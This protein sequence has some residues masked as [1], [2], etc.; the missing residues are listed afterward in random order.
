MMVML[1]PPPL[2]LGLDTA[3]PVPTCIPA[4]ATNCMNVLPIACG[5]AVPV[6]RDRIDERKPAVAEREIR[7][8]IGG[9]AGDRGVDEE[10]VGVAGL[11]G[12]ARAEHGNSVGID[13]DRVGVLGA[14]HVGLG[15][16]AITEGRVEISGLGQ[17][18][19]DEIRI[20]QPGL[21]ACGVGSGDEHQAVLQRK[22]DVGVAGLELVENAPAVAV[23][24]GIEFAIGIEFRDAHE[25]PRL[26]RGDDRAAGNRDGAGAIHIARVKFDD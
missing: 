13:D 23:E 5:R 25:L 12:R 22:A 15:D 11:V 20:D 2:M 17:S 21:D 10:H 18:S 4:A 1:E 3:S 24:V 26:P 9:V 19:R 14:A 8:T 7:L 6:E 16:A